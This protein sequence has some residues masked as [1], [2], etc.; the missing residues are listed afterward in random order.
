MIARPVSRSW[1]MVDLRYDLIN[2][3]FEKLLSAWATV[4]GSVSAILRAVQKLG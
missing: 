3:S 1:D 2:F 4:T